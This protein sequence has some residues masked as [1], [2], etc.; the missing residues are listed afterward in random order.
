MTK[1]KF[2]SKIAVIAGSGNLPK[3]IIETLRKSNTDFI[4]L[5]VKDNADKS[6]LENT[7]HHWI[8]IDEFSKSI[9]ILK[10]HNTTKI[11]FVGH[12]QRPP[13]LSMK[14]DT[15]T[16]L[17][18][19]KFGMSKLRGGSDQLHSMIAKFVEDQGFNIIP[20]ESIMPELLAPSGV[21]G[22]KKPSKKDEND[23][24]IGKKV[25]I[26]LGDMDIGQSVIVENGLVLG[27]EA[28][29]GTD[30]LIKRCADLKKEKERLGVLVK[31]KKTT[32]EKRIDLPAIGINTIENAYN[33]GLKG[34]A[35]KAGSSLI[36][37]IK[38]VI[39]TANEYGIF[40]IGI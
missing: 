21:I 37:D 13:L 40:L 16:M 6:I 22:K 33:A 2:D 25:L 28:A 24:D 18:L 12:I 27:I 11:T 38:K 30:Q 4:V 8:N 29:E 32:Q 17:L 9:K 14:L 20:P 34:I 5:A 1:L 31:M 15:T 26:K 35:I 10:N 39:T 36:I 23:I 19:A 7:K 3:L